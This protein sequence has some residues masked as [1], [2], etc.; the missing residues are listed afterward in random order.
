MH[1]P[2]LAAAKIKKL[3]LL[4]A[5]YEYAIEF[6]SGKDNVYPDVLPSKPMN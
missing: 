5:A 4:L 1:E 6:T 2:Q 3:Q